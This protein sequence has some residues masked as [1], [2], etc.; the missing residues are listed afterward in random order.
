V[1][2]HGCGGWVGWLGWLGVGLTRAVY[3]CC[4]LPSSGAP[5]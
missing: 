1:V 2:L 4:R 5:C 3:A